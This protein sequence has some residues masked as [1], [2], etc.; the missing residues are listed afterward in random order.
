MKQV[1]HRSVPIQE[2]LGSD[3]VIHEFD[4][5]TRTVAEAAAAVGCKE[6]QIAK[7][8][9]FRTTSDRSVLVVASGTNRVDTTKVSLLI[10]DKVT[11]AEPEFV[12][13]RS[14]YAIGAVPPLGHQSPPLTLLDRDL[15]VFDEIW[16]AAGAPNAVFRLTPREL[17]ALTGAD[18]FDVAQSDDQVLEAH[19]ARSIVVAEIETE[20]ETK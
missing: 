13:D 6:A 20:T 3:Y 11:R 16:A 18:Y 14:G 12:R 9:V 4:V 8:L 1:V 2:I 7:S 15:K 17:K 19:N 10:G 5:P